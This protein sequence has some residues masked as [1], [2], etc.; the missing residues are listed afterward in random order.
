MGIYKIEATMLV[1]PYLTIEASSK[2]E[3]IEKIQ[4]EE[5]DVK[6]FL[7]TVFPIASIRVDGIAAEKP[8]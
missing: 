4:N 1:R 7:E 5:F 6:E 3:A 8:A 2:E